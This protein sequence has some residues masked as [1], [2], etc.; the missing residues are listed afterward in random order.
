M[1][2]VNGLEISKNVS[3]L[4]IYDDGS[5]KKFRHVLLDKLKKSEKENTE[6]ES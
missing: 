1:C 5:I 4:S 6:D 2:E 3:A